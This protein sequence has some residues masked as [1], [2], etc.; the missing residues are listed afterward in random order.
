MPNGSSSRKQKKLS[1]STKDSGSSQKNIEA[2]PSDETSK[3]VLLDDKSPN[4]EE[5]DRSLR[6]ATSVA[7]KQE[8]LRKSRKTRQSRGISGSDDAAGTSASESTS[9]SCRNL[10][11]INK[12][13]DSDNTGSR[14]AVTKTENTLSR[15]SGKRRENQN[16]DVSFLHRSDEPK[17]NQ[18]QG[19]NFCSTAD[20]TDSVDEGGRR[21]LRSRAISVANKVKEQIP[22][23]SRTLRNN[24][25]GANVMKNKIDENYS[26]TTKTKLS[27]TINERSEE[28]NSE[29][30]DKGDLEKIDSK[31][32]KPIKRKSQETGLQDK[33]QG[34]TRH[35][36]KHME[37]KLSETVKNKKE[38]EQESNDEKEKEKERIQSSSKSLATKQVVQRQTRSVKRYVESS[39]FEDSCGISDNQT[40]F[41]GAIKKKK[42][43]RECSED[44][45]K[46]E[47]RRQPKNT[48]S[49]KS[50]ARKQMVLRQTRS[51]KRYVE[52]SEFEDSGGISD[53]QTTFVDANKKKENERESSE[54]KKKEEKRGQPRNSRSSKSLATNQVLLK[55]ARSAKHVE[56][57]EFEDSGES[58]DNQPTIVGNIDF[59]YTNKKLNFDSVNSTSSVPATERVL[60]KR[61]SPLGNDQRIVSKVNSNDGGTDT[62]DECE[63][64]ITSSC[65]KGIRSFEKGYLK[66]RM[67]CS[68][69]KP[70]VLEAKPQKSMQKDQR[71]HKKGTN[72]GE[73]SHNSS[74]EV[75]EINVAENRRRE[76]HRRWPV[77]QQK[78]C[79]NKYSSE[80]QLKV[81]NFER[82][83]TDKRFTQNEVDANMFVSPRKS[84]KARNVGF[85]ESINAVEKMWRSY[86]RKTRTNHQVSSIDVANPETEEEESEMEN[87]VGEWQRDEVERLYK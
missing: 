27:A 11:Y 60:R 28:L 80:N 37:F 13:I 10:S 59:S 34:R 39:E 43:E 68:D 25:K 79:R 26:K 81:K 36:A 17:S 15:T 67:L 16:T 57:S 71:R 24:S 75:K 18:P 8:K 85:G 78:S 12:K 3:D 56:S 66:S 55:Q 51:V 74:S 42:D 2:V 65:A 47:K 87:Q 83:G 38:A 31:S 20:E 73:R 14:S 76:D 5:T 48:K 6:S 29:Q 82:K 1:L 35:Y 45:T 53:N 44:E 33:K 4:P 22:T 46:E 21:N 50:L 40:T 23:N 32:K 61:K 7:T 49:A 69:S 62:C 84:V 70:I 54:E 19:S 86:Q 72:R 41:V 9:D 30:E 64:T 58:S 52:S 77:S 63:Q